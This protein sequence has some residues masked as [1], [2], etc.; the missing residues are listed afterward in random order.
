MTSRYSLVTAKSFDGPITMTQ[1]IAISEVHTRI[2]N[3]LGEQGKFWPE[4]LTV[5]VLTNELYLCYMAHWRLDAT[6]SAPWSATIGTERDKYEICSSCKGTRGRWNKNIAGDPYFSDCPSCDGKGQV[7]KSYT[8]WFNQSGYANA[9]LDHAVVLNVANGVK[10]RCGNRNYGA[11]YDVP[12]APADAMVLEPEAA[13]RASGLKL[14]R[15][16]VYAQ[17]QNDSLAS[18]ERLGRVRDI[19]LGDASIK[20]V[21]AQIWLYPMFVGT[22]D[23]AGDSYSVEVDGVTGK[24]HVDTPTSVKNQR[25]FEVFRWAV[26]FAVIFIA[27]LIGGLVITAMFD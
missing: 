18:A 23:Y 17:L 7:R 13:D 11:P 14:A 5:D 20:G 26:I 12:S 6:A 24:L 3:W 15:N 1:P 25:A 19:R 9:V 16:V 21:N 10:F 2:Q 8:E 27:V 4:D 22:Y